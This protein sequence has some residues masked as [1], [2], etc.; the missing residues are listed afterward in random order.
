MV[1]AADSGLLS[2]RL[3]VVYKSPALLRCFTFLTAFADKAGLGI[4]SL[5]DMSANIF[6]YRIRK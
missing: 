1:P 4:I 3:W 2:K 6:L 5:S